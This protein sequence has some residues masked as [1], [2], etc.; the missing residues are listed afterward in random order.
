MTSVFSLGIDTGWPLTALRHRFA[1]GYHR[2]YMQ[3]MWHL[4]YQ[5]QQKI[6]RQN[7]WIEMEGKKK[8]VNLCQ[9]LQNTSK[10]RY[11]PP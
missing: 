9:R 5:F 10:Y 8:C 4:R 6:L 1:A 3:N 7:L 11:L 2:F